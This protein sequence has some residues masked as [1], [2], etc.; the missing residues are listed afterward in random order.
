MDKYKIEQIEE[1]QLKT[2]QSDPN[3]PSLDVIGFETAANGIP[4]IWTD[5][6]FLTAGGS[7][8]IKKI[9][10]KK[11][12]F[13]FPKPVSL[14]KE[15]LMR[16][17]N[18]D[19]C[20]LDFF[21]GSGT[22]AQAVLELNEEEGANR[23]FILCTNNESNICTEI[24]YPRIRT[25]ITGRRV[26][27]SVYSNGIPAN[28]KYYCTDFVSKN[29]DFLSDSLL[30]HITEMIQL[31]HGVNLDGKQ[32]II[33]LNDEDADELATHWK[34]HRDIK[35]LF[36]SKNVLFTTEQNKLFNGVEIN[37]IPDYYFTFELREVG[38]TW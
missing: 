23:S 22:T 38:E 35:A 5:T 2:L 25:V 18:K 12:A 9:F 28:L 32:Y 7:R 15:I 27:G 17:S 30:D 26:D 1:G 34:E 21:A 10:N 8:D 14:I 3:K 20:V 6:E 11:V 37:I 36:V 19:D 31:E 33:L 16:V 29:E 24:T 4:T 13:S